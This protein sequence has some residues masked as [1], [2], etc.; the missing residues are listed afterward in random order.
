MEGKRVRPSHQDSYERLSEPVHP[1]SCPR[2]EVGP[3]C[4]L[5][6]DPGQP[7]RRRK[8]SIG[9]PGTKLQPAEALRIRLFGKF[10]NVS[11]EGSAVRA[12]IVVIHHTDLPIRIEISNHIS[13]LLI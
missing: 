11:V 10:Y 9:I 2:R 8:G 1:F 13:V 5:P 4:G 7:T 12:K 6:R 3:Q